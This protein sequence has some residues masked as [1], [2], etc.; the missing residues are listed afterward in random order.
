MKKLFFLLLLALTGCAT[1]NSDA[2]PLMIYDLSDNYMDVFRNQIITEAD[3]A[4]MIQTYG[5]H[6]SQLVQNNQFADILGEN[7]PLIIV[8]PVD[9]LSVHGMVQ[10]ATRQS[11]PLIFINREPLYEDLS[12]S[13]QFYYIGSKAQESAELQAGII[14]QA[15]GQNPEALNDLDLNGDNHIQTVILMGQQGHQ[16]AEQRTKYV[17]QTLEDQGYQLDILEIRV[18]NFDYRE[19]FQEMLEA[20]ATHGDAIELVIANNDAMA[21]GAV[22]ALMEKGVISAVSE[23]APHINLPVVGIDGLPDA[24]NYIERGLLYG[25]VINDSQTMS[26]ALIDLIEAILTDDFDAFDWPIENDHYIWIEYRPL[27]LESSEIS[28]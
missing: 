21:L 8:N 6:D 13:D 1:A 22:D 15:F 5:A 9:R 27:I 3:G 17:I 10:E 4:W 12:Q 23:E 25:T 2:I 19:A 7:T 28:D 20:Y 24:V 16:D 18:A 14:D 26:E 11:V